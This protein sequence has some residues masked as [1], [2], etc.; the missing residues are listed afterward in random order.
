MPMAAAEVVTVLASQ[1]TSFKIANLG[2]T[3]GAFE[4][5]RQAGI[6]GRLGDVAPMIPMLL[7]IGPT[8]AGAPPP[9]QFHVQLADVPELLPLLAS[10]TP[11]AGPGVA[12]FAGRPRSVGPAA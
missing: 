8:T 11:P 12:S 2:Q 6:E 10:R 7:G 5:D 9:R 1:Y 4:Q 3:V